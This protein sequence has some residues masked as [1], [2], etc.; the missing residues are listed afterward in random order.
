MNDPLSSAIRAAL[1]GD[2]KETALEFHGEAVNWGYLRRVAENVRAVLAQMGSAADGAIALVPRN[3]PAFC[4]ALLA[5][6][7]ERRSIVMCYAFQ[8]ATALAADLANLQV[9]VVVADR[10]DWNPEV[11]D[12]LPVG[13][14][15]IALDCDL[16]A[17]DPVH[18]FQGDP[19]GRI[20]LH[21]AGEEPTVQ[22]LTSG[23]T[24]PPK[25]RPLAYRTLQGAIVAASVLDAGG[26][27]GEPGTV[28]F[29]LSN[30]SGIYS[31]LP[32]A[33]ARR[34]VLLQEKF[35][36]PEWHS[37]VKR[38][39]PKAVILPPAGLRMI[40][41]AQVPPE[42][43][44]GVRYL[45]VGTSPVN[46]D[47]HAEMERRYGVSILLSYGA[48]EFCGAATTMTAEL[49]EQFG[50]RKFG[51]VGKPQPGNDVR[52]VDPDT[53][54][55]VAAGETGMLMVKIGVLGPDY[56]RTADLG[57]LDEDGFLFIKGRTDGVIVRGG[58][59]VLPA[60]VEAALCR[61]PGVAASS[62]VGIPDTRL[63]QVPVA[64]IEMQVGA[65]APNVEALRAHARASLPA[66][67]IP[68]AFRVVEALPR[69]PSLKTDLRAVRALFQTSSTELS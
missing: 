8:S 25:R 55:P 9:A 5:L 61:Y 37:F 39:R 63:G 3:R 13:T 45:M 6:L 21:F 4:A 26:V 11:L 66:P 62:V 1:D 44:A 50:G 65:P 7:A 29:P 35:N 60:T 27:K 2:P 47:T 28:N 31:Y 51:S 23:T 56:I 10:Q 41:D 38:H 24:G 17:K 64:A 46:P 19:P 68:V 59:K 57:M 67:F 12:A 34:L 69:T 18:V 32:M 36:V 15:G 22:L 54:E 33:V 53:G 40:L 16:Q 52:V 20:P 49:Y 43:L 30:I 14:L 48:T 42:D 58:F